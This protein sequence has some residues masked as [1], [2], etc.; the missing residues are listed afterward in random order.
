MKNFSDNDLVTEIRNGSQVAFGVLMKRYERLVYRVGFSYAWQPDS[1]MDIS[2]T[3]FLKVYQKLDMFKASGPFKA[4]LMRI[5]HNES[6]S[7]LRINGR[8]QKDAELT[9]ENAPEQVPDQE[10]NLDMHEQ[11]ESLKDKF[12]EL[13]PKQ[14]MALSMRYFEEMS[15]REIAGVLKCTDGVVKNIL[16]RGLEKLRNRLTL[17]RRENHE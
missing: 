1:A 7:W 11:R 4:W 15:I 10:I 2:Q 14:Q 13:N 6:V 17:K 3:V 5:A 16:F 8:Y 9:Q 12:R